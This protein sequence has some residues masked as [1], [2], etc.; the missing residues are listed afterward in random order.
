MAKKFYKSKRVSYRNNER[1]I[2]A[3][4]ISTGTAGGTI[5]QVLYTGDVACTIR[6]LSI[7]LLPRTT[8]AP[9]PDDRI[10]WAV[11]LVNEGYEPNT[12]HSTIGVDLYNPTRNVL[13]SGVWS[14]QN[15]WTYGRA[16]YSRKLMKG[17]RIMLL[18][19]NID[20]SNETVE[21]STY[22]CQFTVSY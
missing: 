9:L 17:D 5:A 11:V 12:L 14:G 16:K 19:K 6:G 7:K 18:V 3:T 2:R 1:V 22:H 15:N 13:T 4:S 8:N 20:P 21:G 10:M